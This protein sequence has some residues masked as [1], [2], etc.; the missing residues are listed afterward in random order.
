MPVSGQTNGI[1]GGGMEVLPAGMDNNED[2][3][4]E[5]VL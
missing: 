4:K 5:G 3:E 1:G 2:E